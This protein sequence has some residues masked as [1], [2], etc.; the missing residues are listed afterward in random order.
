LT[1]RE[2]KFYFVE[3][4]A[5]GKM[6]RNSLGSLEE[7]VM[8]VVLALGDNAY[9]VGIRDE[10]TKRTKRDHSFGAVYTTLDRLTDKDLVISWLGDPSPERGGRAKRYFK[11]TDKGRRML[12]ETQRIRQ[13][14]EQGLMTG[15]IIAFGWG[16]S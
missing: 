11:L 15:Q 7:A 1:T 9:G 6:G 5:G 16:R 10:L 2:F 4:I 8:L 12:E 14:L 13:E 3:E